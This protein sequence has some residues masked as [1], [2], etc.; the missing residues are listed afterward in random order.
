MTAALANVESRGLVRRPTSKPIKT[1]IHA[2]NLNGV[3]SLPVKM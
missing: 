2:F 3:R 1:Q